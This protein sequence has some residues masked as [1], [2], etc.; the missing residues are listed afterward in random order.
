MENIIKQLDAIIAE[1]N[2]LFSNSVYDDLSDLPKMHRQALITR[3]VA[4]IERISGKNSVYSI[5]VDRIYKQI[6]FLNQHTSSIMG[7]LLALREDVNAGY[8]S[9]LIELTHAELFADYLD[10]AYHLQQSKYKDAAAIITGSTLE[11]H[12]KNLSIKH[13]I[14][15]E[16]KGAAVKADKLNSD[17]A[18]ANAYSK[19]DQK[20]VT[21]WLGLRNNAAH[22]KYNEYSSDQ[23]DLFISSVRNFISRLPA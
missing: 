17:L 22:G 3:A 20:N 18:K 19:M 14:D 2:K 23:V 11:S 10:M 21:A 4:A 12:L 1:Y 9:T 8:I 13:G 7:V 16:S 6:P 5:E 15:I